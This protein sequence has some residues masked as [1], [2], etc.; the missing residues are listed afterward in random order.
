MRA[1]RE[2]DA[3]NQPGTH[4]RFHTLAGRLSKHVDG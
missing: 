3:K 1:F 4:E 2:V